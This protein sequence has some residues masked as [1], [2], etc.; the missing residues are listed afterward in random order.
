M[1]TVV[2]ISNAFLIHTSC[3]EV[4]WGVRVEE[5]T[6]SPRFYIPVA[7]NL[8]QINITSTQKH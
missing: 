4:M 5:K 3:E 6:V 8:H 2:E 7:T 1:A